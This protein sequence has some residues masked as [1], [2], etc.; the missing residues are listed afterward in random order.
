M[1]A[2]LFSLLTLIGSLS[3]AKKVK[4]DVPGMTCV[5]CESKMKESFAQYVTNADKD[6]LVDLEKDTVTL[7]TLK[8]IS[9]AQIK[10]GVEKAGYKATKITRL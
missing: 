5:M 2:V 8:S 4:I 3:F 7:N 1:K 9:D 10:E 6:I